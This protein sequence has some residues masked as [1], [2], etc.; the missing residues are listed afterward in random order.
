MH[1]CFSLGMPTPLYDSLSK[2]AVEWCEVNGVKGTCSG[3]GPHALLT[4][5]H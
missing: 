4:L 2:L 5:G 1:A 3:A